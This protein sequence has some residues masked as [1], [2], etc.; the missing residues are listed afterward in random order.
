MH[1]DIIHPTSS[2][3]QCS[4][5]DLVAERLAGDIGLAL[6]VVT[7]QQDVVSMGHHGQIHIVYENIEAGVLRIPVWHFT[8]IDAPEGIRSVLPDSCC[9]SVHKRDHVPVG[10][11][12]PGAAYPEIAVDYPLILADSLL[13]LL[14][15]YSVQSLPESAYQGIRDIAA[16]TIVEV[17]LAQGVYAL[18]GIGIPF[19]YHLIS[20]CKSPC[21]P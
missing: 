9:S 19:L 16:E 6:E 14:V 2:V 3:S 21:C 15:P 1:I 7:D 5:L 4:C 13:V 11:C 17:V 8:C 18:I 20:S 12:L 10:E